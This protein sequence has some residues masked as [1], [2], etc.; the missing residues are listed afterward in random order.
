M[1]Q[2][3]MTH[4]NFKPRSAR[5]DEVLRPW[6][7]GALAAGVGGTAASSAAFVVSPEDFGTGY[8]ASFLFWWQLSVGFLG[9]CLLR[10]IVRSNWGNATWPYLKATLVTMPLL[11]VLFLPITFGLKHIFPWAEPTAAQ[12]VQHDVVEPIGTPPEEHAA[13]AGPRH[14]HINEF[15]AVYF[16]RT[17]FHGR[18]LGY[19]CVWL[20]ASLLAARA[21]TVTGDT[22]LPRR[23]ASF[24]LMGLV[25]TVTFAAFDWGM[26][27]EPQW[28]STIYG[29][30]ILI[31]G[32]VGALAVLILSWGLLLRIPRVS[33]LRV[34][35]V[36]GDLGNL[37]LAFLM[38]WSYFAFS[39]YLIIWAGNLPSEVTWYLRRGTGSWRVVM[40][41]IVAFHFIVPLF[42][43]MSRQRK[44][45]PRRLGW[46][47]G[48][49]L[50]ANL[51][52]TIWT[53]A[54]AFASEVS[55]LHWSL[56]T[57]LIAVGG[58][59][60]LAYTTALRSCL[61]NEV[62]MRRTSHG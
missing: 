33:G 55:D 61:S 48:I 32:A 40:L 14:G 56:L 34:R 24:C 6:Q 58:W 19:F 8:L 17:F 23:L 30:M 57:S 9:L 3:K 50:A 36:T 37:L 39:Q 49:L 60:I 18:C 44:Q 41:V 53:Y 13:E 20:A 2:I 43:L 29:A 26:S 1:S 52:Q 47:A 42:A 51:L 45:H 12:A 31:S 10:C 22:R 27:L 62:L 25:L 16:G 21:G 4:A 15:Q 11:A 54:P 46:I 59:W 7:L 28:Y 38:I 35:A 5:L